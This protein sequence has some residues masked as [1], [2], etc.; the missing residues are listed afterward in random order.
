LRGVVGDD[1]RGREGAGG[2]SGGSSRR[3]SLSPRSSGKNVQDNKA[4]LKQLSRQLV[5]L[6]ER[7]HHLREDLRAD[8]SNSS[9]LRLEADVDRAVQNLELRI[10]RLLSI[11]SGG[12]DEDDSS[13]SSSPSGPTYR[14]G[15][16]FPVENQR[17]TAAAAGVAATTAATAAEAEAEAQAVEVE[18]HDV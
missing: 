2:S 7:Q 14:K 3:G 1:A 8:P 15:D 17:A 9:A 10:R 12:G 13:T 6:R 11:V 5:N 18:R 4:T 16:A